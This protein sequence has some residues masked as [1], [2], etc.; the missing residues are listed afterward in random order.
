MV[1]CNL[2]FN[3]SVKAHD[4]KIAR[5]IGELYAIGIQSYL[6]NHNSGYGNDEYTSVRCTGMTYDLAVFKKEWFNK[7]ILIDGFGEESAM[8]LSNWWADY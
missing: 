4:E 6:R 8:R 7:D 5:A 2:Y 1:E 3:I